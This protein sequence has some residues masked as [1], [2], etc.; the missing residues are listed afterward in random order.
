MNPSTSAAVA[1]PIELIAPDGARLRVSDRGPRHRPAVVLCLPIGV[2]AFALQALVD[3]LSLDFR[4]LVSQSRWVQDDSVAELEAHHSVSLA[5]HAA[6]VVQIVNDLV[7]H[8]V[9]LIGYCSGALIALAAANQLGP[10]VRS[11]TCCNG[12]YVLREHGSDYETAV[13]DLAQRYAPRP[14]L[15]RVIYP[16]VKASI[17]AQVG[18]EGRADEN[19][20]PLLTQFRDET[21]FIKYIKAIRGIFIGNELAQ[22]GPLDLPVLA[23]SGACDGMTPASQFDEVGHLLVN[24]EHHVLDGEDHYMPCR[25]QSEALGLIRSF[26][27]RHA[28]AAGGLPPQ[29]LSQDGVLVLNQQALAQLINEVGVDT[30]MDDT[31]ARLEVALLRYDEALVDLRVRDGFH[32]DHP[33]VGL[34]EWM[35]ILRKD[36]DVVIKLVGYH[37][38]NPQRRLATVQA[39]ILRLETATGRLNAMVEGSFATALRT[40]AASAI[41]TRL[42]ADPASRIVGLVGCGAQSVTQLHALSRVMQIDEVLYWDID[43]AALATF[44]QRVEFMGLRCRAAALPDLEAA[45]DVLCT[46]TS[47]GVGMGPVILGRHLRPHVHINAVGADLPG[48]TELP[49]ALLKRALVMVDFPA[50]ARLEGECQQLDPAEMGPALHQVVK[51]PTLVAAHRAATTVF[52]STGFALQDEAVAAVLIDHARA[53][54]I[55]LRLDL[56]ASEL[57]PRDP[58]ALTGVDRQAAPLNLAV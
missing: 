34:V 12:A 11:L 53:R 17:Q 42:C 2:E 51:D 30:L 6:D 1:Q 57:D 8:E 52:D 16:T 28:A 27:Q 26:L 36:H 58:Y 23:L 14:G 19:R 46:A 39:S 25:P 21:T 10:R 47:V 40:G 54:G 9:H 32:Y 49:L 48:K 4:V 22:L 55:G 7:P 29:R 50:Q 5:A 44:E 20:A 31:I 37:P 24:A 41:A 3:A 45:S 38:T 56:N 13:L 18:T 43:R 33:T 15:A 35:P